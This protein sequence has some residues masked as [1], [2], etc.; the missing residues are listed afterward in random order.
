MEIY[1]FAGRL[2]VLQKVRTSGA[3]PTAVPNRDAAGDAVVVDAAAGTAVHTESR[4]NQLLKCAVEK[5]KY[6]KTHQLLLAPKAP[7][8]LS[9]AAAVDA[10]VDAAAGTA[11]H[12]AAAVDVAAAYDAV[13]LSMV[14]ADA[15]SA[16]VD[17]AAGAA[18]HTAAVNNITAANAVLLVVNGGGDPLDSTTDPFNST[19]AVALVT[20]YAPAVVPRRDGTPSASAT[21]PDGLLR[22]SNCSG[23]SSYTCSNASPY[24]CCAS[25]Y[26]CSNASA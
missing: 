14:A 17:A 15:A 9:M 3:A 24:I 2:Q 6:R 5:E 16:A 8:T 22:G 7:S 20:S 1:D 21:Q 4:A 19:L 12:T 10:V 13:L 18:V 25:P 11:V 26:I 23:N